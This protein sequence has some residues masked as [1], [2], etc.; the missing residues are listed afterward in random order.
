MS[1]AGRDSI[2]H[3]HHMNAAYYYI[4][5]TWAT[6]ASTGAHSRMPPAVRDVY[7]FELDCTPEQ[8]QIRARCDARQEQQATKWAKYE[9]RQKQPPSGDKLK[10]LCRKACSFSP[11]LPNP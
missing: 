3:S 8:L 6:P 9:A 5:S 4:H 1:N 7:G 10:N 11:A 2:L